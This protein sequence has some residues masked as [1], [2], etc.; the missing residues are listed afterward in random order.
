[1]RKVNT[2]WCCDQE[3]TKILW[4]NSDPGPKT[5]STPPV[6]HQK[7]AGVGRA[8]LIPGPQ[9]QQKLAEIIDSSWI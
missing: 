8:P 2:G 3:Y 7:A 9:K 1:M 6:I 5:N 4:Q